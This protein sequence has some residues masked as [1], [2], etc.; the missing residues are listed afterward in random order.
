MRKL[1][2]PVI[3]HQAP[4]FKEQMKR[5]SLDELRTVFDGLLQADRT[6]KSSGLA[7]RL[8]LERMILRMCGTQ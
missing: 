1:R 4:K 3:F 6:L 8:V 7:G 2:P 5:F